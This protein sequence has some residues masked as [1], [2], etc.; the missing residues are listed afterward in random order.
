LATYTQRLVK[1]AIDAGL[2]FKDEGPDRLVC[3]R[4]RHTAISSLLMKG[5]PVAIV[6]EL[7]GT[8]AKMISE[9]YGHIS[10]ESLASAASQL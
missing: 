2:P 6:A 1:E 5:I 8:S 3:Y 9:V 7:V 10:N 4:F